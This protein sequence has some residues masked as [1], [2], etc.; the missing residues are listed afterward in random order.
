M[1][2]DSVFMPPYGYDS[3]HEQCRIN[4]I[5]YQWKN[6]SSISIIFTSFIKIS[7]L[8]PEKPSAAYGRTA[9]VDKRDISCWIV[10]A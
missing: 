4:G 9:G 7:D 10:S 2:G 5:S 3:F 6:G 8:D 1:M